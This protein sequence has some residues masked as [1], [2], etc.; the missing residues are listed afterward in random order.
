MILLKG[1]QGPITVKGSSFNGAMPT[2]TTLQDKQI[3]AVLTYVRQAWGNKA[4]EIE[5]AQIAHA[6]EEFKARSEPWAPSDILAV[7]P[8]AVLEGAEPD[9]AAPA[10][11]AKK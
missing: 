5:P 11:D 2:W 10:P 9:K 6:R 4:G 3:A 8:D 7:P 1:L